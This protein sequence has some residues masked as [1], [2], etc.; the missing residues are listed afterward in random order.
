MLQR[1]RWDS[2]QTGL[3]T[4]L[5]LGNLGAPFH[6][7]EHVILHGIH[8][9]ELRRGFLDH[10]EYVVPICTLRRIPHVRDQRRDSPD[11]AGVRPCTTNISMGIVALSDATMQVPFD[12]CSQQ[13]LN[14]KTFPLPLSDDSKAVWG[15][16]CNSNADRNFPSTVWFLSRAPPTAGGYTVQCT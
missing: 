4:Y 12:P 11:C 15:T 14:R 13:E 16:I 6:I 8:P 7:R 2:H 5:K 3:R 10:V 9:D 1:V